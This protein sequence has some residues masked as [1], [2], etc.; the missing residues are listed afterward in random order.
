METSKAKESFV[1]LSYPMLTRSNSTTWSLKMKVFM[2][3]QGVWC[4]I[5]QK[6]PK[7]AV[8][9]KTVQV[10]LA[11]IYQGVPEDVFLSIAEKETAKEAWEAIKTMCMGVERVKEAKV[12]T[13]KGEFESLIMKETDKIEDFCMKLSGIVI[14]IRV[15][16][17]TMEESS[18]VRK[19]LRAVPDKFLQIASNIEQFGDVKGMTIE[20]VV[21][22]LK[23]HEERM[24]GRS[25]SV[26]GQLLLAFQN[27]RAR[28]GSF[29]DKSRK[30]CY[31]CNTMGHYAAECDKPRREREKRQ[32]VNLA[33]IEDDEPTLL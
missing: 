9:E 27:Q 7:G 14:N 29:R 28:G 19:I 32:E 11:A 31:N 12:Q 18:V 24:K 15:L 30:K 20:E 1:G 21:G 33:Q 2:K 13:L 6:D 26:D 17:E 10:A 8:D 5:E 16:G 3:A 25:E 4:T 23:A 22:R